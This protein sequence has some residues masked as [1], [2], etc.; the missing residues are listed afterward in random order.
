[1]SEQ[2]QPNDLSAFAGSWT[3]D[4]GSTSV[5]FHTKAL[6]VLPV[7]GAAKAIDGG[8]TVTPDGHVTGTLVIDAASI[9]TK[10]R[11]RDEHLRTADFFDVAVYPTITFVVTAARVVGKGKMEIDGTL[12]VRGRSRPLSV[13]ANVSAEEKS[14]LI[15]TEALID[16]SQWGGDLGPVWRRAQEPGRC[17]SPVRSRR[18]ESTPSD[19]T[20]FG[21]RQ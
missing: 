17:S 16:R 6:W 13:Q 10:N 9:D 11:K 15:S 3:L 5:E 20:R 4:T 14:V 12:E 2:K 19:V 21:H 8:G 1:M 18:S 7:K